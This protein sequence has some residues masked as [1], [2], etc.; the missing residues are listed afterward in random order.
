MNQYERKR[1]IKEGIFIISK[2]IYVC[3]SIG[4]PPGVTHYL[5]GTSGHLVDWCTSSFFPA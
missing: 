1:G 5:T 4:F 2:I 3:C